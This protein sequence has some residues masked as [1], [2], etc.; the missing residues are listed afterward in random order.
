MKIYSF[1]FSLLLLSVAGLSQDSLHTRNIEL[2]VGPYVGATFINSNYPGVDTV[3]IS[4]TGMASGL[5]F[6]L[7]DGNVQNGVS[8]FT[9]GSI[10]YYSHN[11][12]LT[13]VD[14]VTTRNL[15]LSLGVGLTDMRYIAGGLRV[16]SLTPF[17]TRNTT[18]DSA[19][20]GVGAFAM[21][22]VPYGKLKFFLTGDIG[23]YTK[24]PFFVIEDGDNLYGSLRLG[25]GYNLF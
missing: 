7:H 4:G 6:I 9:Q 24:N 19:T 16:T 12:K 14:N 3:S 10:G 22:M 13:A 18:F 21:V 25:V 20:I 17:S 11:A 2:S 23:G 5:S 15:E 1:L 8:W